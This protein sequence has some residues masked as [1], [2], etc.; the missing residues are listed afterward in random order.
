MDHTLTLKSKAPVTH[1]TV[2]LEFD[3]PPGFDFVPGQATHWGL[4]VP[5]METVGR[6][7]TITSLPS[8]DRLEFVIKVYPRATHPDHDGVT[9][10]IGQMQPGE[11]VFVD[12]PSGDIRDAGPGVFVAGGAGIT[13]FIPILKDRARRQALE[14]CTLIYSTKSEADIIL[15]GAWEAMDGLNTLY[16]TTETPG[17]ANRIDAA[18]IDEMVSFDNRFYVCGPPPMMQSVIADLRAYGVGDQDIIAEREWLG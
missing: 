17:D 13:P 5:G 11:K 9:E 6:P 16:V 7:F 14:G 18:F 1:D 10:R 2:L 8:E 4:D 3:R 12:T 15:R